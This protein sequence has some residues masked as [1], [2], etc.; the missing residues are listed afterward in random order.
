MGLIVW[1]KVLLEFG[2]ELIEKV[3]DAL[4]ISKATILIS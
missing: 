3:I 1:M 4:K 2:K